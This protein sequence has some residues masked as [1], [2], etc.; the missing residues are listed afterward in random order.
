MKKLLPFIALAI[1]F[2]ACSGGNNTADKQDAS[3]LTAE[4][5]QEKQLFDDVIAVHDEVMSN[6]HLLLEYKDKADSVVKVSAAT[7]KDSALTVSKQL[8]DADSA[9]NAWMHQFE[10][11]YSGKSHADAV[12]YLTEQKKQI[13]EVDSMAKRAIKAS[14]K[15]LAIKK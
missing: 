2:Q 5:K 13:T 15:L 4:Q 11:D 9:M 1:T 3:G 7:A 8:A 14:W 10:P 12:K 6:E